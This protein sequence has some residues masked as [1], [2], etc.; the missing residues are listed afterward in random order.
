M[1][2]SV[3]K[4]IL[5]SL[6]PETAHDLA[7]HL[8]RLGPSLGKLNG[9][10]QDPRLRIKVG[11]CH[12]PFPVGLAAGLDKNAEALDFFAAQGFGA[13]ECGTVTLRPQLGNPRPRIF[14]YPEQ[15]SLRNAMGFPNQGLLEILPRV[16]S[17]Q[18]ATP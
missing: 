3:V 7:L 8:A 1:L 5:F 4:K 15:Q 10:S 16:R 17:F 14:R 12:W 18:G 11:N 9:I 2:Y 6:P 13:V